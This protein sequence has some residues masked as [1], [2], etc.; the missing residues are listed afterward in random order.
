MQYKFWKLI[1]FQF[2]RCILNSLTMDDCFFLCTYDKI[3]FLLCLK[4][5]PLLLSSSEALSPLLP[6]MQKRVCSYC[7]VGSWKAASP[8]RAPSSSSRSAAGPRWACCGS[9]SPNIASSTWAPARAS[10]STWPT[11]HSLWACSS[12]TWLSRSCGGAAGGTRC[13]GRPSG[14]WPLQDS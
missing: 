1:P 4:T 13:L 3:N 12:V 8:C 11:P 7:R 10:A 14:S 9:G 6:P 5:L 2:C